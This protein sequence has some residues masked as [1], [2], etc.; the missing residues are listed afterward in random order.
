VA[1]QGGQGGGVPGHT[2]SGKYGLRNGTENP[3]ETWHSERHQRRGV[4]GEGGKG[5][6]LDAMEITATYTPGL[7]WGGSDVYVFSSSGERVS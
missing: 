5:S 1:Q 7:L 3:Y 4:I 6:N 2:R